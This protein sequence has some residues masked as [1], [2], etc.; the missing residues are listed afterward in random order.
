MLSA[1]TGGLLSSEL[2]SS[3]VVV[4]ES[5]G[6]DLL[7]LCECGCFS[8][9][10]SDFCFQ[11]APERF[12]PGIVFGASLRIRETNLV[13]NQKLPTPV[14]AGVHRIDDQ[15]ANVGPGAAKTGPGSLPALQG[16][17]V[18]G[19]RADCPSGHPARGDVDH[20]HQPGHPIA[21]IELQ[22]GEVRRQYLQ[23]AKVPSADQIELA[24]TI[25]Q[26]LAQR[27]GL[28]GRES[29]LQTEFVVVEQS[30]QPL[31]VDCLS[32]A[33]LEF[34]EDPSTTV[35]GMF[36][37]DVDDVFLEFLVVRIGFLVGLGLAVVPGSSGEVDGFQTP[38]QSVFFLLTLDKL[39]LLIDRQ[40]SPKKLRSIAIST[41]FLP[42]SCSRFEIFFSYSFNSSSPPKT[43]EPF[44]FERLLPSRQCDRVNVVGSRN[45]GIRAI[46][47]ESFEYDLEL[48][49]GTVGFVGQDW[50]LLL[51]K[52]RC[53]NT[54]SVSTIEINT[55]GGSNFRAH[56]TKTRYSARSRFLRQFFAPGSAVEF[57]EAPQAVVGVNPWPLLPPSMQLR[58]TCIIPI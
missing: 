5:S 35:A 43:S 20:R 51:S 48:E 15:T 7:Q 12:D 18:V 53:E 19:R 16:K 6:D 34:R 56:L 40:L 23:G 24:R 22:L 57:F 8:D 46:G 30:S 25:G 21:A 45:F 58:G 32:G 26:N 33:L 39:D 13:F 11:S 37:D 55:P 1:S 29:T 10:R 38:V 3:V 14:V 52:L 41:S 28:C 54:T 42:R 44:F 47:R 36:G 31:V 50:D 17:P 4:V 27:T 2:A 49:R 9:F